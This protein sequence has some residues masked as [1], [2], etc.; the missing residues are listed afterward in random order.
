MGPQRLALNP[1][2]QPSSSP[3]LAQVAGCVHYIDMY[4]QRNIKL[5]GQLDRNALHLHIH[6][7]GGLYLVGAFHVGKLLPF[8][9]AACLMCPVARL[10]RAQRPPHHRSE[11]QSLH[12]GNIRAWRR[13]QSHSKQQRRL[14][15]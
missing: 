2:N 13:L 12:P 8:A 1:L 5:A 11:Q 10:V 4:P 15:E 14:P 9:F 3:S 6:D 7:R